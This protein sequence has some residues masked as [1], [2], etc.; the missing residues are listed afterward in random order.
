MRCGV[1]RQEAQRGRGDRRA[2]GER[3]DRGR[4]LVGQRGELDRHAGEALLALAG[5]GAKPGIA[6]D[7]LDVA[8]AARDAV[9]DIGERHILTSAQ[10]DL[11]CHGYRSSDAATLPPTYAPC[12][13]A[14][15]GP[16]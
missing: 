12:A 15:C 11:A 10:H 3:R 2:R 7:L 4:G 9:L 13:A 5:P 1:T 14:A 6:L 8:I 16:T